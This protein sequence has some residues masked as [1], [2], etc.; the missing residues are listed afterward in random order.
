MADTLPEI[1]FTRLHANGALT[2]VIGPLKDQRYSNAAAVPGTIYHPDYTA[3]LTQ[4]RE[5][6]DR[7]SGCRQPCHCPP[8]A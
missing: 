5:R 1:V 8:W 4:A 3:D 6:A 7:G 2:I